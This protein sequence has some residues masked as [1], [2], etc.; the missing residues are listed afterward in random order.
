[1][2][3]NWKKL[4]SE[5]GTILVLIL[6]G[7]GFS[8]V[9]MEEQWPADADAAQ[10]LVARI[11]RRTMARE[12]TRLCLF[13]KVAKVKTFAE[14]LESE[15]KASGLNV[16]DA[17]VTQPV[18][19]RKALV[20]IAE[21]DTPLAVIAADRH[22]ANFCKEQLPKLAIKYPLLAKAKVYTPASYKWPNF[23]K[24]AN[25][26]NIMKQISVVAIIAIGMTMIII[27]AGI[28]LSVGS[29]VAFSGVVTAL[30]IQ[31]VGGDAPTTTH[32][33]IGIATG[34]F[35]CGLVGMF[36]GA[37]SRCSAFPPSS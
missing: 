9:T 15:L 1:M 19:A 17:A 21:S 31:S 28:D 3:S 8:V 16:L 6:L 27:T 11:C 13:G 5:Y 35:A 34:V 24:K 20:A 30:A 7:A 2:N 12:P 36:T 26:L 10:V 25:L 14:A 23:L 22:M 29:L 4:L 32:L 33:F 37:W 18:G